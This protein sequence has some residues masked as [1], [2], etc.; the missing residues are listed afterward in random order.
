[1]V[2]FYKDID[3][4]DAAERAINEV[5]EYDNQ[6]VALKAKLVE[7]QAP[8]PVEVLVSAK[9][10]KLLDTL[11]ADVDIHLVD[12]G[13]GLANK[14]PNE[15]LMVE[16]E[17]NVFIPQD[18]GDILEMWLYTRLTMIVIEIKRFINRKVLMHVICFSFLLWPFQ[19]FFRIS[20]VKMDY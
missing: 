16:E 7:R 12:I 10:K 4:T 15:L 14:E 11:L 3:R 6:I 2:Q 17:R 5:I 20:N 1:M 9:M 13:S 19:F 8:D 18:N